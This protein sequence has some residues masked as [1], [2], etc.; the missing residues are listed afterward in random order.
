M[1]FIIIKMKRY[2]STRKHY[3]NRRY[4]KKR[5]TK[6]SSKYARKQ[7]KQSL[8]W[9]RKKYTKVFTM[10]AEQGTDSWVQTV[11]LIGGRNGNAPAD[12]ICLTDVN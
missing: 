8:G 11:S 9:I 6:R 7:Q 3:G 5:T 4:K 2:T 10:D 1:G 12:T